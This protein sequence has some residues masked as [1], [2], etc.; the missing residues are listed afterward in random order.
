MNLYLLTRPEDGQAGWDEYVG[1]VVAA[2]T[3]EDARHTHPRGGEQVAEFNTWIPPDKVIVRLIGIA[4]PSVAPGV[5]M[6]S[7]NAR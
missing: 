1:A 5:V 4:D 6:D 3:A 2:R 7:F